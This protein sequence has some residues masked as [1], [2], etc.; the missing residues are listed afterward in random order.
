MNPNITKGSVTPEDFA[1]QAPEGDCSPASCSVSLEQMLIN[2]NKRLRE[3]G[4]EL[5]EAAMR[6]AKT[7]G[8]VHR[9]MIASSKWAMAIADEG[10][11]G[12]LYS[13]NIEDSR[14]K[15]VG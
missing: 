3:A 15:G 2:D 9:L 4:C 1:N 11:R 7:Y 13:Q 12:R 5:A 6:V 14:A 10:E 8:G